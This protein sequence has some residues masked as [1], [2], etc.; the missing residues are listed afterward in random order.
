MGSSRDEVRPRLLGHPLPKPCARLADAK[1]EAGPKRA[2][3]TAADEHIA[4]QCSRG[5][6]Q[7]RRQGKDREVTREDPDLAQNRRDSTNDHE[8]ERNCKAAPDAIPG[9]I[10]GEIVHVL[11]LAVC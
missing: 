6:D 2:S 4:E 3:A 11:M 1:P 9:P 5:A 7:K 10:E 8:Y